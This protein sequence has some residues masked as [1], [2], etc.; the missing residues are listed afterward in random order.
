MSRSLNELLRNIDECV[1]KRR[2]ARF[3]QIVD[4]AGEPLLRWWEAKK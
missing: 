1:G 2:C 3:R 4:I